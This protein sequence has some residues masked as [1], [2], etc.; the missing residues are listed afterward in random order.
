MNHIRL[1]AYK[2]SKYASAIAG[3]GSLAET[4][5]THMI[6]LVILITD[7]SALSPGVLYS[8]KFVSNMQYAC[9]IQT[10]I[11]LVLYIIGVF[12]RRANL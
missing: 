10:N 7:L 4:L 5:A 11:P 3:L 12:K 9:S 2:S 6:Y 1:E 8:T